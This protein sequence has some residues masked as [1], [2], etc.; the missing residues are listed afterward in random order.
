M[1][2]RRGSAWPLHRTGSGQKASRCQAPHVPLPA[3]P[4][5]ICPG[6]RDLGWS[7]CPV[8]AQSTFLS[9][10]GNIGGRQTTRQTGR[11][12]LLPPDLCWPS[13]PWSQEQG[14]GLSGSLHSLAW[15]GCLH[16]FEANRTEE[17]QSWRRRPGLTLGTPKCCC[18]A[19]PASRLPDSPTQHLGASVEGGLPLTWLGQ[20]GSPPPQSPSLLPSPRT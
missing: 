20:V 16:I 1:K 15:R 4:G 18:P 11:G 5:K 12:F 10:S 13:C 7:L 9:T 2:P 19:S 3:L 8:A 6:P 17:A 14:G